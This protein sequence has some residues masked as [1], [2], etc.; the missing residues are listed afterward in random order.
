MGTIWPVLLFGL[1]LGMKHATEPDHVIAVSTIVSRTKKLS[2]SSLAGMFWGIG[3]TLTLLIV[4][5]AMIAFERQIPE[6]VASYLEMVVGVMI[7]ILGIASFRSPMS[8]DHHRRGDIHHFHIKST[9]IGI[10]HG[11]AGSA[12]MV[13]LTMTTVKGTWMAFSFILLF[14]LGTVIGM[15]LFTTL[16]GV[17]FVWM[18]VKRQ[19]I[20]QWMVK[21]V[22]LI[23]IA[24]GVYYIYHIT[25]EL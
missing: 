19:A 12:G 1:L 7:V 22:S 10:V 16:L 6:Q 2:L 14:G 15:M 17:P 23:S 5:M 18:K 24:Y 25:T 13:L 21:T 20:S 8:M 11:L 4:G 3:H 9:L